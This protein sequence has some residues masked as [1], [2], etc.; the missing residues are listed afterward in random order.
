MPQRR[1]IEDDWEDD[2]EEEGGDGWGDSD[3]EDDTIPCPYCGQEMHQ[4]SPRCPHCENYLS[5]EDAPP[6]E[7][8]AWLVIGAILGLAAVALWILLGL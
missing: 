2:W 1:W 7:K 3:E 4:D 8:P 5:K 6:E